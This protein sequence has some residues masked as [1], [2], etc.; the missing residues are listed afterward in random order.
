MTEYINV[1]I[2]IIIGIILVVFF[3][4]ISSVVVDGLDSK[5]RDGGME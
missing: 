2:P 5:H 3:A 4:M 1:L